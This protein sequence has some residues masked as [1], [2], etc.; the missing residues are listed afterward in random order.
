MKKLTKILCLFGAV[1]LLGLA[2]CEKAALNSDTAS[3]IANLNAVAVTADTTS[4]DAVYIINTCHHGDRRDSVAFS[5]LPASVG[6]YLTANYPGYTFKKAFKVVTPSSANDGFIVIIQ[7]E[8]KPVGLKFDN[9]GNFVKVF[10]QRERR[11]LNGKGWRLG[12]RFDCRDGMHRDTIALS[13]LPASIKSY[14]SSSFPHD[15]LL[16]AVTNKEGNYIVLSADN[17]MFATIFKNDNAFIRRVQLPAPGG[18]MTAIAENAL[19]AA[20]VSYLSTTYPS[21]TFHK[22]VV[23]KINSTIQGYVVLIDANATKYALRFDASGNFV[24][25]LAIKCH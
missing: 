4:G 19:P 3:L 22:A 25:N 6:T 11:D 20:V 2:S 10:E 14:Y 21:Y 16:H 8:D 1:A 18:K 13:A 9:S 24:K 7:F 17:G 23:V 12:G 5:S 15:T